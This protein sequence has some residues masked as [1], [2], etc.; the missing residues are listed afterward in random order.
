MLDLSYEEDSRADV[1]MNVVLTGSGKF[2]E[3]QATAERTPFDD[4]QWTELLAYARSG[5]A[6][7]R[8]LQDQI[9]SRAA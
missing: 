7:L 2:V 1:D 6:E 5:I 8:L 3:F 9:L 4:S